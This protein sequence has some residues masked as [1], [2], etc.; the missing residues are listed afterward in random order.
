MVARLQLGCSLQRRV[1]SVAGDLAC[2]L[3][4][5]RVGRT[6]FLHLGLRGNFQGDT[7]PGCAHHRAQESI[8]G[9]DVFLVQPSC[10][11]VNDHLMEL[12]VMIDA[13]KRAS[14]RSITAVIPYYGYAR[15]DR[16][17]QGRE[18]IAAKL[19]ANLL[20]EAG[21]WPSLLLGRAHGEP[22][23]TMG[24]LSTGPHQCQR[25]RRAT[26]SVIAVASL[27]K[28][29]YYPPWPSTPLVWRVMPRGFM[30]ALP[31]HR[32]PCRMP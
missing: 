14:A 24:G 27:W 18:S 1:L 21:A 32:G 7:D 4:H 28:R 16:K 25:R 5:S 12:L 3:V 29:R 6:H 22:L 23:W 8:R 31:M 10:P 2:N 19:T 17:T 15:A 26:L 30:Q 9:C 13:C 11:P 20:T